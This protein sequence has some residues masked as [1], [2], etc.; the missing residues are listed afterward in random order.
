[1]NATYVVAGGLGG[2]CRSILRWMV[3]RGTKYLLVPSRSGPNSPA[4]AEVIREL[5]EQNIVVSTPECD[6][7]SKDALS[8]M[9]E[10]AS[11]TLPPIQGYIVS[12]MALNVSPEMIC[13]FVALISH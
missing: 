8:H 4:A 12:T 7:S 6:V 10:N 5:T 2:I 3:T 9:L 1:M 11:G 13:K